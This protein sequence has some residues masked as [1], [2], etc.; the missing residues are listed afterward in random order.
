MDIHPLIL[1]FG[2]SLV[3]IIV[4]AA[5][6]R[7]MGLGGKPRLTDEASVSEAAGEVEDGFT[8]SRVSIAKDGAAALARDGEG[9]IM[10]IRRHGNK[11]AGR[12]LAKGAKA[13]EV[14]DALII[15]AKD[16][17]FGEVRMTLNDPAY[18]ADAVNRL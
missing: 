5:L 15:D 7:A 16:A 18:W 11:F 14:V 3:A 13:R 4:V 9:R 17:R 10:V 6:V 2:G 12:I 1:Q 8:P